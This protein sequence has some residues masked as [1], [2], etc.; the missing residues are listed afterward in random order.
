MRQCSGCQRFFTRQHCPLCGSTGDDIPQVGG[1]TADYKILPV[2]VTVG[3]Q[4]CRVTGIVGQGGHGVVLALVNEAGETFAL[5]VPLEFNERFTNHQGNKKSLLQ[6]SRKYMDHEVEMAHR[7]KGAALIKIDY[8]G[9]VTCSSSDTEISFP[10]VRMELALGTLKDLLDLHIAGRWR[11]PFVEKVALIRKLARAVEALHKEA[12]VHRDISP[13]NIFLVDRG[14]EIGYVF[15]DLGTSQPVDLHGNDN[16]TTRMAFHNRYL[17]PA[18]FLFDNFRYD[19]RIDI[20]QVGVIITEI[21]MGEYWQ[22]EEEESSV[23]GFGS[24]D[25]TEEYL[26]K[27]ARDEIPPQLWNVLHKAVTLKIKHRYRTASQ[28]RLALE[29]A[30]TEVEPLMGRE[31]NPF[32]KSIGIH[33]KRLILPDTGTNEETSAGIE[34]ADSHPVPLTYDGRRHIALDSAD[35]MDIDF[36]ALQLQRAFIS[37]PSFMRCTFSANRVTVSIDQ[38]A[39]M[40]TLQP[41]L[42]SSRQCRRIEFDGRAVLKVEGIRR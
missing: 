17:D 15:G 1:E 35:S 38:Q 2:T 5:K 19:A 34:G 11:I 20:Y 6:L 41:L 25:F 21:I 33:Y 28:F 37:G 7:V 24:T 18:L 30:L 29:K 16:S 13:H 12:V 31:D 39:V 14:G 32:K 27:Y 26:K 22:P 40:Q 10:A 42:R 3:S 23:Y 9:P 8:A 4:M 36:P